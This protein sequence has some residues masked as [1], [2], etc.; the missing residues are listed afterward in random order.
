M[1]IKFQPY[2]TKYNANS[3]NY[4]KRKAYSNLAHLKYDT[5]SFGAMKKKQF[6]GIDLA[7]VEKFKAPVEKFNTNADLQKWS[8]TKTLEIANKD[9]GGR[10]DETP[11]QRKAMLKEWADYVLKKNDGYTNAMALLI[12]D[13]ITKD[14]KPDN[15]TIPPVLNK[16][17]LADCIEEIDKNTKQNPK[18]QFDL[19]KIYRNKLQSFYLGDKQANTGETS[20]KW[21]KIPSYENDPEHFEEN[22]NKLKVLSCE[23][24]CTKSFNAEPYLREGDFHVYLENGHPKIGVRFIDNEIEEIQGEENNGKIPLSH[25][26]TVEK[27]IKDEKARLGYD[28]KNELKKAKEFLKI[29]TTLKKAIEQNDAKKIFKYFGIDAVT[30]KNG[31]LTISEYRQPSN[32]IKYSDIGIDENK[33]FKNI[34][35]ISGNADFCHSKLTDFGNLQSI[36]GNLFCGNHT[37]VTNLGNLQKI[38]R[39]AYFSFSQL[40]NLG[41][42]EL[43]GGAADFSYTPLTN[44]GNLKLI[45]GKADFRHTQ[46]TSLGNLKSIGGDAYFEDSKISNLGNLQKIGG[47]ASFGF[48]PISNLGNLKTIGGCVNFNWTQITDLG[49][50]QKIGDSVNF[51]DSQVT[52]LGKLKS[53]GGDAYFRNSQIISLGNLKSIGGSADFENSQLT[54][55]GNLQVIGRSAI[56]K[57]SKLTSLGNLEFIGGD[58]YFENSQITDPKKLKIVRGN[59]Y[60]I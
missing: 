1:Q 44:L 13:A 58:A 8:E 31:F 26:G 5:I 55:L 52:N 30:D 41:K 3:S 48:S 6:G 33:L 46:L 16:G 47:D 60:Y 15:D 53:I 19:N 57:H 11:I 4:S 18:Y 32:S 7:V 45:G 37:E 22:V 50:L 54:S 34:K 25:V 49:N 23:T 28:A 20:T 51:G 29:K 40:T 17:V 59:I 2:I 43:I 24:W 56:F 39:N 14:L 38:G 9:F 27:H 12:L 36:G 42:L 35:S 10:Q 21:V